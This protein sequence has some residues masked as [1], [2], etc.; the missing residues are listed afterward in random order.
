MFSS[1][2]DFPEEALAWIAE[3]KQFLKDRRQELKDMKHRMTDRAKIT[4]ESVNLGKILEKIVP[5]FNGFR[6]P[7][8]D[9]RSLFEPIDYVIFTGLSGTGA[10][11]EL[12]FLDVKSGGARLTR[13][14][15]EIAT[16]IQCG[17][18]GFEIIQS[19]NGGRN[20]DNP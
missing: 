10:V 5:S 19:G 17:N 3:R 14:Q 8:Q 7:T 9:C 15:R 11:D 2:D 6:Y 20:G 1:K 16:A 4:V 18:V 12:V 13:T